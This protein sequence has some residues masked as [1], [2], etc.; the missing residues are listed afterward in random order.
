MLSGL[1]DRVYVSLDDQC[2]YGVDKIEHWDW[3]TGEMWFEDREE[4][5]GIQEFLKNADLEDWE[6]E[7]AEIGYDVDGLW[8]LIEKHKK[9]GVVA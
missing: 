8:A 4:E 5:I 6:A 1:H 2:L 9:M 7:L 3:W